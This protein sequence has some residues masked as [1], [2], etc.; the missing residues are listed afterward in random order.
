MSNVL[1]NKIYFMGEHSSNTSPTDPNLYNADDIATYMLIDSVAISSATSKAVSTVNAAA[2]DSSSIST[3]SSKASSAGSQGSVA[4]SKAVS[5]SGNTSIADSKSISNSVNISVAD[6]KA[7]SVAT[8]TPAV[9]AVV[10]SGAISVADSKAVSIVAGVPASGRT[11]TALPTYLNTNAVYN[12]LDWGVTFDGVTNDTARWTAFM[13]ALP[14]SGFIVWFPNAVNPSIIDSSVVNG[15]L[16]FN[17]KS[18]FRIFGNG[19]TLK[20]LAGAACTGNNHM[21]AFQTCT[22]FYVDNLI[23]DGNR[24]TRSPNL[25]NPQGCYNVVVADST[26]RGTF[27]NVR[28]INAVCDGF[29]VNVSAANF[30]TVSAYPTDITLQ[31]CIAD[32]SVRCGLSFPNSVRAKVLGGRYINSVGSAPQC[33]IDIES[34]PATVSSGNIDTLVVDAEVSGNTGYGLALGGSATALETNIVIDGLRGANNAGAWIN[35]GAGTNVDMKNLECGVHTTATRGVIDINSLAVNVRISGLN[36]Y[37]ITASGGAQYCVYVH[38]AV[39]GTVILE[40]LRFVNCACST[41]VLTRRCIVDGYF[42]LGCTKD[43]EIQ[44][45]AGQTDFR[46]GVSENATGRSLYVS[47]T[48]VTI[49]GFTAIDAGSATSPFYIDAGGDRATLL[50]LKVLQR[51]SIPV[52]QVAL[53]FNT[54]VIPGVIRNFTARSASTDYTTTTVATFT[55]GVVG[56]RIS[57]MVPDPFRVTLVWDP[58][59]LGTLQVA[60]T[61]VTVTGARIGD[62]VIVQPGLDLG[63]FSVTAFVSANDTVR[64]VLFNSTAGTIDTASSTWIIWVEKAG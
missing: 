45:V 19:A 34:D 29:T 7:V 32:N 52:G 64:I 36:M 49:D 30:L 20:V 44:L 57:G 46:N 15:V 2:P 33:G 4:D 3:A 26:L 1:T 37:G 53:F 58:A 40:K 47:A 31:N 8:S 27:N 43:P 48:D 59:S 60:Q 51:T 42:S 17:G 21:M 63:A 14:A 28:S 61:T 62:K 25:S 41:L 39:T 10:Y 5:G 55:G 35:C 54:G 13:A 16:F 6:S 56:A 12:P 23:L 9:T 50:N 24:A 22:D 11:T 18:N 38:S